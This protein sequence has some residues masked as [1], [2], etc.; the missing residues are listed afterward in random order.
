MKKYYTVFSIIILLIIAGN[1]VNKK[2]INKSGIHSHKTQEKTVYSR[3]VSMSPSITETLFALDLGDRVV[4]VTSF[5]KY[6]IEAQE[7]V[8]VGGYI[9]PNYEAL[10]TLKPDLVII[11]PEHEN[12]HDYLTELDIKY[13]VVNNKKV[14]DIIDAIIIIGRVCGAEKRAQE[15]V[16]NIKSRIQKIQ[17][18]TKGL[19]KPRV[20]ISVGRTIGSGSLKDVYIAGGNTF[21]GELISYAGGKNAFESNKMKY[22]V[23]SAEGFLHLNPDIIIDM[24]PD[25]KKM[26][27]N[28]NMLLK[29]WES[30]SDVNAVRNNRVY[31]LSQDYIVSPGPRFIMLL[32]DLARIINTEIE[33]NVINRFK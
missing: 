21:F 29:E 1:F 33:W 18:Q 13:L 15:L 26:G 30:I 32:E 24:V 27:L 16:K 10:I 23:L 11:L 12:I 22:P 8:N 14:S 25:I 2:Q 28:E 4:G 3:I 20:L 31:V 9:D 6:P 7:K 5:C 17:E 19:S